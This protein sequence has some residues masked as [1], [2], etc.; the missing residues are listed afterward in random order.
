MS[1]EKVVF[2]TA[3]AG[4][5][6]EA[7]ARLFSSNGYKVYLTDLNEKSVGIISKDINLNGGKT[8][9]SKL[10]VTHENEWKKNLENCMKKFNR[11]DVLCNNAGSNF[12]TG[13]ENQS[14]EMW[15]KIIYMVWSLRKK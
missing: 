10:D 15:N 12:R 13:F 1:N 2:I 8:S 6:G 5:I 9:F 3:S 7:Q 4:A 14:F 11:I